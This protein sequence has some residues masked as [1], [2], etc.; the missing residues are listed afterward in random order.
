MGVARAHGELVAVQFGHAYHS[1]VTELLDYG[2][3]KRAHVAGQ[4]FRGGRGGP[5]SGNEDIFMSNREPA[6]RKSEA[7]AARPPRQGRRKLCL[8]GLRLPEHEADVLQREE[9]RGDG[10]EGPDAA[11]QRGQRDE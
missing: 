1:G 6:Q 7:G 11:G 8:G 9:A 2:G 3:V 10:H 4:D 5:V